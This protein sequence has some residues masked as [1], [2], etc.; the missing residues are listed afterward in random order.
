M[1]MNNEEYTIDTV[2]LLNIKMTYRQPVFGVLTDLVCRS[3]LLYLIVITANAKLY[4]HHTV[5]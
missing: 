2:I 4:Q 5:C 3:I 1:C